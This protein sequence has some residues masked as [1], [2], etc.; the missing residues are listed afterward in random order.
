MFVSSFRTGNRCSGMARIQGNSNS[1]LQKCI[2]VPGTVT[3]DDHP[4]LY[5]T[6]A[7]VV[8]A[9]INGRVLTA[10]VISECFTSVQTDISVAMA[11]PERRIDENRC[12]TMKYFT[13]HR[14]TSGLE[15]L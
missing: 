7:K 11:I 6:A 4:L 10:N 1:P 5:Q 12:W 3:S 2:E 15:I 9:F 14:G 8:K 13:E